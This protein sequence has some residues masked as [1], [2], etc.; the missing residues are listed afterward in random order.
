MGLAQILVEI[1]RRARVLPAFDVDPLQEISRRCAE[2][3]HTPDARTLAKITIA[4]GNR[5]GQFDDREI[6][7]LGPEAL[8]LLDALSERTIRM[9]Q[10]HAMD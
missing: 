1:R 2:A 5:S 4:I 9:T 8:G 10:H 6:W 7:L 3:P